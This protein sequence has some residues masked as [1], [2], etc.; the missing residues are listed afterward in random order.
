MPPECLLAKK[1]RRRR[2]PSRLKIASRN[3]L[4]MDGAMRI[5]REVLSAGIR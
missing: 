2:T 4:Q 1:T 3:A 5:V